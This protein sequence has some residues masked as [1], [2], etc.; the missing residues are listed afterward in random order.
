VC[1]PVCWRCNEAYD[2][3]AQGARVLRV[4]GARLA[5]P[6]ATAATPRLLR[7]LLQAAASAGEAR[8]VHSPRPTI[9]D[10]NPSPG[11]SPLSAPQQPA[12]KKKRA[13]GMDLM[14]PA[15][16]PLWDPALDLLAMAPHHRG[17]R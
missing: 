5:L 3:R 12:A 11:P 6:E 17:A 10:P 7:L 13:V 4:L 14:L 8:R 2:R 15:P 1:L 16:S 9:P